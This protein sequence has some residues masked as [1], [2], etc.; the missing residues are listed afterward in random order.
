[1]TSDNMFSGFAKNRKSEQE[2]IEGHVA[3]KARQKRAHFTLAL[4]PENKE[5]LKI[6]AFRQGKTVSKV[7]EEWIDKYID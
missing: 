1:M 5:K 6:Y 4:S 2:R 7:I 3:P